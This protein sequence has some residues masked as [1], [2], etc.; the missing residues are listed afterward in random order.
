MVIKMYLKHFPDETDSKYIQVH[1]SNSLNS[2]VFASH[3]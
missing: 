1:G 2:S 3:F